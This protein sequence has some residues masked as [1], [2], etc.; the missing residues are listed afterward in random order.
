MA[1]SL[2]VDVHGCRDPAPDTYAVDCMIGTA[3][4]EKH[5]GTEQAA[6]MCSTPAAAAA[7]SGQINSN[8]AVSRQAMQQ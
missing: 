1:H 2:H 7:A 8:D 4:M 6:G 5:H 3:A